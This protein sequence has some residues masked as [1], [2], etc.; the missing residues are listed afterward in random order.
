MERLLRINDFHAKRAGVPMMICG[1]PITALQIICF[2]MIIAQQNVKKL[3]KFRFCEG[4]APLDFGPHHQCHV[5]HCM[6]QLGHHLAGHQDRGGEHAPL[7]FGGT[8][9][10]DCVPD[11]Y[12]VCDRAP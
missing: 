8:P 12:R 11:V 6:L 3:Y 1:T 4:T 2:L 9:L 10:F 5:S 7:N